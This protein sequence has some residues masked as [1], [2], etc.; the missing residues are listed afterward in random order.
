MGKELGVTAIISLSLFALW[1][2]WWQAGD[3]V[4]SLVTKV[5]KNMCVKQ[6]KALYYS[7]SILVIAFIS[8]EGIVLE[9]PI[10]LKG[11]LKSMFGFLGG[12]FNGYL[13]IGTI[14]NVV[15]DAEYFWPEIQMVSPPLSNLH[16]TAIKFLPVSV[17]ENVSPLPFLIL[18]MLL[19]LAIIW[20]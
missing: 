19:L 6:V 8:Y 1:V 10:K 17:M 20:K 9:F 18:G 16:N 5:F 11:I 14:W 7:C 12:L 2:G 4:V 13:I 3:L 15:A